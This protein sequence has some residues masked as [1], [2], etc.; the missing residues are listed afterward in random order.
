MSDTSGLQLDDDGFVD[1]A[2]FPDDGT[3]LG[4]DEL[5][6]LRDV[7][8]ADPVEEPTAEAWDAMF[9]EV[10]TA[11]DDGPFG[12]DDGLGADDL[13]TDTDLGDDGSPAFDTDDADTEPDAD[14][15]GGGIVDDVDDGG[16]GLDDLDG[17]DVD[18]DVDLDG[19][20]DVTPTDVVDDHYD[21]DGA[22][23]D[24]PAD[25]SHDF[26]DTL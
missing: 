8:H 4:A 26:E 11:A 21:V 7:L 23:V 15:D 17:G 6:D 3:D 10:V 19:V 14:D 20:I 2:Q 24:T 9:D 5:A 13:F 22:D 12:L 18:L 25:I 16:L 1:M